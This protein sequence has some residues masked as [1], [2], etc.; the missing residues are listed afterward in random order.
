MQLRSIC[1]CLIIKSGENPEVIL[2]VIDKDNYS[3]EA[4]G[5]DFNGKR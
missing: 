4:D 2:T 5:F 1:T 3:I